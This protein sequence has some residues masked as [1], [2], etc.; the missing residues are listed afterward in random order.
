MGEISVTSVKPAIEFILTQNIQT[1]KLK[2]LSL[3][4]CSEGGSI[5]AAFALIDIMRGS[6]IPIHTIG[7]GQIASAALMIF[8]AGAQ[9][10]TA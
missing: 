8:I 3:V 7:I 2:H 10:Q 5:E 6:C 1:Q 9:G 4:I